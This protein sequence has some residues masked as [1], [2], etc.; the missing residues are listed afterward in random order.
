MTLSGTG[1]RTD[2]SFLDVSWL[3]EGLMRDQRKTIRAPTLSSD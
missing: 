2:K 3:L 1:V